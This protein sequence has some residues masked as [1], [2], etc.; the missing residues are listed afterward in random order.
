MGGEEYLAGPASGSGKTTL[1]NILAGR[2]RSS[3]GTALSGRVTYGGQAWS[4][5]N[6]VPLSY[7]EQD[8]RFFSNLTAR[9]GAYSLPARS[10]DTHF[11]PSSLELIGIP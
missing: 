1:L 4:H 3:R 5:G 9:P 2:I 11:E 8:P 6:G 7:V 10:F